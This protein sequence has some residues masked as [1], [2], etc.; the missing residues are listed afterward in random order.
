VPKLGIVILPTVWR[1][2]YLI[3]SY[4]GASQ[5]E[6]QLVQRLSWLRIYVIFLSPYRQMPGFYLDSGT[7]D[8]L[9]LPG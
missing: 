8:S 2:G 9:N 3:G 5:F 4:L 7:T 1:S 6:T